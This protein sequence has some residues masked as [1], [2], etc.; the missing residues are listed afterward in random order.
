MSS[1]TLAA[2]APVFLR[3]RAYFAP[4]LRSDEMTVPFD[5]ATQGR[6]DWNTPP[7]GW[8]D[9]GDVAKFTPQS[10][11]VVE[12]VRTGTPA[13]ART[14]V[15]KQ[16]GASA[17]FVLLEWGKL[18]AALHSG[19]QHINLLSNDEALALTDGNT[20]TTL[21]VATPHNIIAGDMVAV[22]MDYK[23]ETGFV[24]SGAAGSYVSDTSVVSTDVHYVRRVTFNVARVTSVDGATVQLASPLLA[25][26]PTAEMKVSRVVGFTAREGGDFFQ[27][28]SALF[29]AEGVQGDRLI[30]H[31]PRMQTAESS[32]ARSVLRGPFEQWQMQMQMR[33]LPVT[34]VVDGEEVF[35]Y[36]SYLPAPMRRM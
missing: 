2:C 28:W 24:G 32:C 10:E 17:E 12:A 9:A 18:Q 25:G 23:G 5:V 11:T 13:S 15:R 26:V 8:I 16:R 14:Q 4:V 20:A 22:D 21:H 19:S 1:T 33:A 27:E 29:V 31:Y 35:C 36:R 7:A 6:F 34:D 30:F 3:V